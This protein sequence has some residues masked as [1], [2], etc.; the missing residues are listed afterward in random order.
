MINDFLDLLLREPVLEGGGN[1]KLQFFVGPQRNENS[2]GYE[3][4]RA[5]VEART[6]PELSEHVIV[7]QLAELRAELAGCAGIRHSLRDLGRQ[8]LRDQCFDGLSIVCHRSTPQERQRT[9]CQIESADECRRLLRI[10]TESR[11]PAQPFLK[12]YLQLE[13]SEIGADAVMRPHVEGDVRLAAARTHLKRVG[14]RRRIEIDRRYQQQ[15]L[16]TLTQSEAFGL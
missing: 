12:E 13:P 1:V 10:K 11:N 4:A 2:Q 8:H 9:N 7:G 5:P 3:T 16:I 14:K 15:Q 6:R